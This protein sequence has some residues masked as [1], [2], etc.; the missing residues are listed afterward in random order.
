MKKINILS[1]LRVI[2]FVYCGGMIWLL[3]FGNRQPPEYQNYWAQLENHLCPRPFYTITNYIRAVLTSSSGDI[4]RHCA[5]NLL[6]NVLL[7]IPGGYLSPKLWQSFR[8]FWRFLLIMLGLLLL[9][10]SL[11]LFTLR[12][13]FDVDDVLLNLF[14]LCIGYLFYMNKK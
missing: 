9:I 4:V 3:F 6:G 14:G 8:P 11:Q 12:G 13:I 10:E 5:V 2:F 1:L 7:F